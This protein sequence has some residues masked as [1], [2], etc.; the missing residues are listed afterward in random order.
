MGGK[1]VEQPGIRSIMLPLLEEQHEYLMYS[2][3]FENDLV[4][5]LSEY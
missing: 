4:L 3:E 2:N 1:Y 5:I